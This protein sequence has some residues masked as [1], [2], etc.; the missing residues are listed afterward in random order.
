ML[1]PYGGM[2]GTH[3]NEPAMSKLIM[4]ALKQPVLKAALMATV[5]G[6]LLG[7]CT[8]ASTNTPPAASPSASSAP[9]EAAATAT[10]EPTPTPPLTPH[11][12]ADAYLAAWQK[13]DYTTMY[14][15]LA[16]DSQS[17]LTAEAFQ[18]QYHSIQ[19][20]MTVSSLAAS[21]TSL[22]ETGDTAQ[23][24][25]H[26]KYT[27][28]LIGTLETD[29]TLPLKREAGAWGV[30]YSPSLIWPQIVNGQTLYMLPDV[31]QR[32]N[33][34]D[35]N[36]VPMV[37]DETAVDALGVV[38]GEIQD[39]KTVMYSL[40]SLLNVSPKTILSDYQ[41][42]A[43][44]QYLPLGEA[45]ASVVDKRFPGL[46]DLAG[47][48]VSPYTSRYYYGNGA[49]AH[50]T[51]YTSYL[52]QDELETYLAQG[53]S[54]DQRIGRSGLEQWG[55]TQLA[56]KNGGSLVL[57]S[58]DNKPIKTLVSTAASPAQDITTTVDFKLQQAVE[59]AMA[60]LSGA[61][62]VMNP[63]TG[64]V[65]ALYS[66]P[67]YDPNLFDP[68]NVN[69]TARS[70]ILANPLDPLNDRAAQSSFPAGSI[71]KVVT[72][73]AGMTSGLFT[74]DSLYTCNGK[75]EELPGTVLMDWKEAGHG[76]INL[77]QGLAGSCNP[78]FF[79]IGYALYKYNPQWL[80]DTA[81]AFG[82][83]APTGIGQIE[84]TGGLIPDP[85][86]KL[87]AKGENWEP[88]DSTNGAIGQG[89]TLVTP[90]QI[91]R[92]MSAVANGGTLYQP[93]LVLTVQPQGG[94]PSFQFQPKAVGQ[95][96]VKPEQ[97]AAIQK[98]L[99]DVV[100]DCAGCI[101]TA[102]D[103]FRGLRVVVAGKTGTAEDPGAYGTQDPDAWFTGYT[104]GNRPDKPDIAIAVVV[105][106]QGEGSAFAAPIFR[107]IVE[108]YFGLTLTTYPWESAV[109]VV[110]TPEPT[111]TGAVPADTPTP[112]P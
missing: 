78:Y 25:A 87:K 1:R 27:T 107:R 49:A 39:D 30:V 15:L 11:E 94:P 93:Q 96:P 6:A 68:Y 99:Q 24:Q 83:G 81:H 91:A 12:A 48:K 86:W 23:A 76:T 53:Y 38:P 51:G 47:V 3:Y 19:L 60:D 2:D 82:L 62:V 63:K 102:R 33:I 65:L 56:G 75:F 22:N 89:D 43:A 110:K 73:A 45:P 103:K 17:T 40:A 7:A 5:V 61:A 97:L 28:L 98:G 34:Y 108:S 8:S 21:V 109:G 4:F 95:L 70:Q 42:A 26:V 85:A 13:G 37:T 16:P 90:L 88:L 50:I 105:N 92:M 64:E 72:M 77:V 84:E 20:T 111:P 52:G 57:M 32:G 112:T 79:H 36:G 58:P 41:N 29:V 35:R 80:P 55:E 31:P 10:L 9:T 66:S 46:K 74:P 69:A 71:F 104:L 54:R 101:G 44:D 18:Q 100:R 67:T 59:F 14:D 106:N